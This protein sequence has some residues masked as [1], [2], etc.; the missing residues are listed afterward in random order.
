MRQLTLAV[1]IV[2]LWSGAGSA[3]GPDLKMF[4][5]LAGTWEMTAGQRVVE[6]HWTTPTANRMIGMSRTVSG[7]RTAEF[8]FLRIEKRGDDLFYV[9]QPNGRPPVAFKLT[10]STDGRF[11]FENN[12]AEDHVKKIEYRR[13]GDDGLYAR[14]DGAQDGKPFALEFRYRRRK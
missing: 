1:A 7:D 6:E 14:V 8:E 9:P 3:Q 13:E 10:S 12:T 4:G 2:M 11:I 5:W